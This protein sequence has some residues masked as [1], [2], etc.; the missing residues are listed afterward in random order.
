MNKTRHRSR[1]LLITEIGLATATGLLT[2]VT[3]I[4]REWIEIV[5]GVDPD[6]G[7]GALEWLLVVVL[8]ATTLIFGLLAR[9][10]WRRPRVA[11]ALS[12]PPTS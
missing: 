6:Q 5:F 7:S 4:S 11:P 9:N 10:E 2:I 12:T 3:L 1:R 8:A